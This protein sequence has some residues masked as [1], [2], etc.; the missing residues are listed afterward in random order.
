MLARHRVNENCASLMDIIKA[1]DGNSMIY[2]IKLIDPIQE[3]TQA[4]IKENT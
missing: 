2:E 4:D 3:N 1:I